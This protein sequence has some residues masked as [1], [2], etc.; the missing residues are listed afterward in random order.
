MQ[1]LFLAEEME[2]ER[3][4]YGGYSPVKWVE[5]C[6]TAQIWRGVGWR[7]GDREGRHDLE[8]F[9]V[10]GITRDERYRIRL[11]RRPE[12]FMPEV[13]EFCKVRVLAMRHRTLNPLSAKSDLGV[14]RM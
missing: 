1:L 8:V 14:N 2:E 9:R 10:E 7:V 6:Q 3:R 13:P 12:E 11:W 4:V 5:R